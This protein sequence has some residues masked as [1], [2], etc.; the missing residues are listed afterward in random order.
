MKPGVLA[1]LTFCL[2]ILLGSGRICAEEAHGG[3]K[4]NESAE[5]S[6]AQ[7]ESTG[8]AVDSGIR[9]VVKGGGRNIGSD[10]G[11]PGQS[12]TGVGNATK[13]EEG[14]AGE[15]VDRPGEIPVKVGECTGKRFK[16]CR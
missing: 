16:K 2:G 6:Q 14:E 15:S 8:S 1:R 7:A 5:W 4:E 9:K 3:F 11:N 12:V 13:P 10:A